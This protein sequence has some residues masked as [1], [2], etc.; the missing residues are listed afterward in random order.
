MH[1]NTR[2]LSRFGRQMIRHQKSK[3]KQ[4]KRT[5]PR[6]IFSVFSFVFIPLLR[7][8]LTRGLSS[9]PL[10]IGHSFSR[11]RSDQKTRRPVF[12]YIFSPSEQQSPVVS[13]DSRRSVSYRASGPPPPFILLLPGKKPPPHSHSTHPQLEKNPFPHS[14]ENHATPSLSLSLSLSLSSSEQTNNKEGG[15][16]NQ[17]RQKYTPSE[18]QR[19]AS[20]PPPPPPPNP[21]TVCLLSAAFSLRSRLSRVLGSIGITRSV[22]DRCF[23]FPVVYFPIPTFPSPCMI[24]EYIP[25]FC[26]IPVP[27]PT[28]SNVPPLPTPCLKPTNNN[29][30][31]HNHTHGWCVGSF[32]PLLQFKRHKQDM[33]TRATIIVVGKKRRI[34]RC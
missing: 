20:P 13:A 29:K 21:H 24:L 5:P 33:T 1:A 22:S 10:P 25:I 32:T 4:K 15:K 16:D 14:N 7:A 30:Q 6:R 27:A 11:C 28:P 9:T 26:P 18:K 12:F 2:E 8:F 23:F 3:K 17:I 34:P 19:T 31:Q